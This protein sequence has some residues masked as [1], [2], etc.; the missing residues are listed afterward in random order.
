MPGDATTGHVRLDWH[1]VAA[2]VGGE[3][4]QSHAVARSACLPLLLQMVALAKRHRRIRRLMVHAL[5]GTVDESLM[6]E[7]LPFCQQLELLDL[8]G[9]EARCCAVCPGAPYTL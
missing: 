7:L 8:S 4:Q 6:R 5:P 3:A 9:G 2:E 1:Q